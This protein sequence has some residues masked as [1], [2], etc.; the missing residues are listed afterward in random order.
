MKQLFGVLVLAALALLTTNAIPIPSS[1]PG[2]SGGQGMSSLP[3]DV[4]A[5][6]DG[7]YLA[8]TKEMVRISPSI[9]FSS[10]PQGGKGLFMR[11]P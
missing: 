5:R 9:S 6:I 3:P 11:R 7:E 8:R 4:Q 2:V 10:S 1:G